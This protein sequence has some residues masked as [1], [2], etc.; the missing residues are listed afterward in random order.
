MFLLRSV[1]RVWASTEVI[2]DQWGPLSQGQ[3]ARPHSESG[4]TARSTS[5]S[6][7]IS[8][9]DGQIIARVEELAKKKDW[10]MSQVALA[11]TNR[12]ISSPIIGFSS[13]S[14]IDEAVQA[15]GKKLTAEEEEYLEEP[16]VP[17]AII[18]H[19]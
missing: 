2:P 1:K 10:T 14:R 8:E 9:A 4:K 19:G 7:T 16:Y 6:Q 13:V 5:R 15:K 18:G 17:K 11:W 12:R 3:L